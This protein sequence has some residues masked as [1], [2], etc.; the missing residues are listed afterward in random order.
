MD[1]SLALLTRTALPWYARN[2]AVRWCLRRYHR[3][4]TLTVGRRRD[5]L[6]YVGIHRGREFDT[7]FKSYHRC[8]GFE[9]DPELF[10]L[11]VEKYREHPH[12][13]LFNYA[14][15]EANGPMTLN[16]SSNAGASSS[17]GVFDDEWDSFR[18]GE[19]TM[20]KQITVQ[21]V[22]LNDFLT[23]EGVRFVDD[24]ISDIQGM[25]LTVLR[26]LKPF[27]DEGRIGSITVET[28]REDKGNIY[29]NLP[30]NQESGFWSLL[31]VRYKLVAIGFGVLEDY[32]FG[33]VPTNSWEADCK[34]RRRFLR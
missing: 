12:V 33:H 17:L 31:G 19:I 22:N 14:A 5:T 15:A 34:W 1:H 16:I 32:W 2:A 26:T 4:R 11:L 28:T 6:V 8:Y 23:A 18:S 24:Y 25:D 21:A 9:A 3:L 13:K 30:G 10:A 7:I 20:V 27:I 29:K